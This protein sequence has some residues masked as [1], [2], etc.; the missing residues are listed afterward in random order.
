MP[1]TD[2]QLVTHLQLF[3]AYLLN[4]KQLSANTIDNYQRDMLNLV[5]WLENEKITDWD[6]LRQQ[7]VRRFIAWRQSAVFFSI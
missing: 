3:M 5:S 4:E 6:K 1:T 2:N 7:H